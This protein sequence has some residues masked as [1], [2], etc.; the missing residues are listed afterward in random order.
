MSISPHTPRGAKV[1]LLETLD[2]FCKGDVFTVADIECRIGKCRA[3]GSHFLVH[4]DE[5]R[6][7]FS[8]CVLRRLTDIGSLQKLCDMAPSD[9]KKELVE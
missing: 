9:K 4:V 1:V 8:L 6:S 2:E 5:T 3:C 7:L